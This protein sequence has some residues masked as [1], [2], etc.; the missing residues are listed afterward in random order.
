MSHD[1]M[2]DIAENTL[3]GISK[4]QIDYETLSGGYWLWKAPEYLVTT[5]IARHISTI[6]YR[7]FYLTLENN[8]T[9]G[10]KDAG[11]WGKGR[12]R[13]DLRPDGK[14]DML[15]W[16]ANDK[17]R[18]VIEVKNQVTG[19]SHIKADISRICATLSRHN[20]IRCGFI[21]YYTSFSKGKRKSARDRVITR[22][23]GVA[24][25]VNELAKQEKKKFKRYPG[26]VVGDDNDAWSAE[27]LK[28]SR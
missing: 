4:A 11:G 20:T 23:D 7:T 19:F 9:S 12:L 5:Y 15:L 6:N 16:W 14:F 3:G 25:K 13:K 2:D 24:S 26:K 1:F 18:A 28:I 22:V 27:V 8:V 17:P 10:I 21:A